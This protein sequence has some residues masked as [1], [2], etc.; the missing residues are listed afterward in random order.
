VGWAIF[1]GVCDVAEELAWLIAAKGGPRGASSPATA[2]QTCAGLTSHFP[3]APRISDDGRVA[4]VSSE[5]GHVGGVGA[6]PRGVGRPRHAC[7]SCRPMRHY[8]TIHIE[9]HTLNADPVL[10]L[11]VTAKY[12]YAHLC[13]NTTCTVSAT[14]YNL[15]ETRKALATANQTIP[16]G[17]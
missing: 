10:F 13:R 11:T 17:T 7:P 15:P 16:A 8:A 12:R 6:S 9:H 4:R 3:R 14:Q 5:C 2:T 1:V